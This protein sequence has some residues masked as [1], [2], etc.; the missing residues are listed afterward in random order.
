MMLY[1][2]KILKKKKISDVPAQTAKLPPTS[3]LQTPILL[4][5]GGV[6]LKADFFFLL[7]PKIDKL[8][9]F[10]FS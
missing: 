1:I 6:W 9:L 2:K 7:M 10:F 8:F 5:K 4:K 3:S